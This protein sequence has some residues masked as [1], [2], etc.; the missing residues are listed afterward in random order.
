ML[1]IESDGGKEGESSCVIGDLWND[2]HCVH[3]KRAYYANE[4][5]VVRTLKIPL[6]S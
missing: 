1:R 2:G 3:S 5:C 4:V 6:Y